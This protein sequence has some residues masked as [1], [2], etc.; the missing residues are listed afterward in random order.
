MASFRESPRPRYVVA[1]AKRSTEEHA[2]N[3][4]KLGFITRIPGPRKL[5]TQGITLCFRPARVKFDWPWP[6]VIL[7]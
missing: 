1:D 3:L 6:T 4:A 7:K 5:V 2:P